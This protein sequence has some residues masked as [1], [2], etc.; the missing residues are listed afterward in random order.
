MLITSFV[1]CSIKF[2]VTKLG[3]AI[4]GFRHMIQSLKKKGSIEPQRRLNSIM[5]EVVKKEIIK[6]LEVGVIYPI[7]ERS[8]LVLSSV[9]KKGWNDND[10]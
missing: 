6:W 4:K 2:N 10:C 3:K 7:S 8:W 1:F 9:C 5:K